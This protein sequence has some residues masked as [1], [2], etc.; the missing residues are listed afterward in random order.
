MSAYHSYRISFKPLHGYRPCQHS[1]P[2]DAKFCP[3]C[4][5]SLELDNDDMWKMVAVAVDEAREDPSLQ[6]RLT[7]IE[8]AIDRVIMKETISGW[9]TQTDFK[10]ITSYMRDV[11]VTIDIQYEEDTF[12]QWREYYL[13]GK[14]QV[15]NAQVTIEDLDPAKLE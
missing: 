13:N 9:D 5:L 15:A 7:G 4:G 8:S 10:I 12:E 6:Y 14:V 3:E 2:E 11:L 1:Y